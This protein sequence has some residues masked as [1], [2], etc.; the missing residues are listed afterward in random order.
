LFGLVGMLR[1]PK[2]A[3]LGSPSKKYKVML[4]EALAPGTPFLPPGRGVAIFKDAQGVYAISTTCTHLGCVIKPT[5]GGFECPCHGSRFHPD[6]AVAKGP[7]PRA[8]PWFK[9]TVSGGAV[10]VD[11]G[12]TIE[13]GT[14]AAV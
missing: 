14:K 1:L 7:A 13:A 8:L 9:V 6:G 5:D 4:P 11:E 10:Q 3:V 2:A 12:A